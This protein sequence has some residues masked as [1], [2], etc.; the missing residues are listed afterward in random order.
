MELLVRRFECSGQRWFASAVRR[1]Q[2]AQ[3]DE[4]RPKLIQLRVQILEMIVFVRHKEKVN[5][6]R[7][8]A[9][10]RKRSF[11]SEEKRDPA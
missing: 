10:S 1:E 11:H 2:L 6:R 8:L 3:F 9:P 4:R 7:A 5:S